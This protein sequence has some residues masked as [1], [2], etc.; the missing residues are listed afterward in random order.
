MTIW[1]ILLNISCTSKEDMQKS[2]PE[3]SISDP[4]GNVKNM[5]S[6]HF[7][8]SQMDP[9]INVRK[10]STEY[11]LVSLIGTL[12]FFTVFQAPGNTPLTLGHEVRSLG[13]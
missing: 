13:A 1:E 4:F 5:Q 7:E 9:P 10:M 8:R 6:Q 2:V 11:V 3:A 12:I